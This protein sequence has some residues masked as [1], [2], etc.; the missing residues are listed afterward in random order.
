MMWRTL[1]VAGACVVLVAAGKAPV[2]DESPAVA[3]PGLEKAFT[4]TIV[5][6]YPDGRTA[7]LWMRPDGTFASMGRR[8]DRHSGR[9]KLKGDKVCFRRGVFSYCTPMPS[10]TAFTTKAVTGET[11]QVR[12]VPGRKG[13][14]A[15]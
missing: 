10:E 11:I 7:K 2:G 1:G 6:T 13:E 12:L 14:A 9:W 3:S 8:Q 15:G 4:H 5:S